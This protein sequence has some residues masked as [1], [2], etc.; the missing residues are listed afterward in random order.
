MKLHNM[1]KITTG[2]PCFSKANQTKRPWMPLEKKTGLLQTA[3]LSMEIY[4]LDYIFQLQKHSISKDKLCGDKLYESRVFCS[5]LNVIYGYMYYLLS[6][7]VIDWYTQFIENVYMRNECCQSIIPFLD[8]CF[9]ILIS[10][11][12]YQRKHYGMFNDLNLIFPDECIQI[13]FLSVF[14]Y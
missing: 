2:P 8:L 9:L 12:A 3:S 14:P 13:F 10:R 7:A 4:F 1:N 6:F 5:F 11:K